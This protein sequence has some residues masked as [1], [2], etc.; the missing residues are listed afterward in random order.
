MIDLE[1][2]QFFLSVHDTWGFIPEIKL[3]PILT[4]SE[5]DEPISL[6]AEKQEDENYLFS[7]L[8]LALYQLTLQYKSFIVE[9]EL[10]IPSENVDI[11]FPAEFSIKINILDS[12]G[13]VVN[14]AKV[15]VSRGGKEVETKS[16]MSGVAFSLPPGTYTVKVYNQDDLIGARKIN[17]FSQ[18]SFD[19]VTTT[20]PVFSLIVTISAVV[21]ALVGLMF[22]YIKK[23]IMYFLKIL[24][25][26][27][28]IIAVVSPWWMLQGSTN[29]VETSTTMHLM[30]LELVTSTTAADVISGELAYLPDLFIDVVSLIP[31]FTIL[32]CLFIFSSMYFRKRRT[33]L[34]LLSLFFALFMFASS[35]LIF[36]IGMN[37]LAEVGI[38]S[39]VGE[40]NLEVSIPG[41]EVAA[42][43]LCSWGPNVGFYLYVFSII[44]ISLIIIY[45]VKKIVKKK[46]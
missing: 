28:V 8:P 29:F 23:D 30:P 32:G 16:N 27:L 45:G 18:R 43:V 46:R 11:V 41:E 37:E 20:E 5:M 13:S 31:I 19:I 15:V 12:R 7:N 40:G 44:M 3:T 34:Y 6:S 33:K 36:S 1:R 24:A 2:H 22:T 39:F 9:E 25:V 26:S 42:T 21:F 10:E 4:S 17:V 14:G 35:I 38:G